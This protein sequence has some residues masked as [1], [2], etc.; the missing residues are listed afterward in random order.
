MTTRI[1][2]FDFSINLLRALLWQDN[3][4]PKM[5]ALL[6]Q[7]QDWYEANVSTFWTN[8]IADV[9]DIRTANEFGLSVWAIIL[10]LP[11]EFIAPDN[12]GPQF[13]FGPASNGRVNFNHGNFGSSQAGVGLTLEQKRILLRLRYYRLINRCSVTEINAM[14]A[15]LLS[16]Y[17][18]MYV[19][20][21]LDM[22]MTY[23]YLFPPNSKLQFVL[24]NF[25]ILPRPA[26]V[27]LKFISGTRQGIFGFG[28]FNDN[29]ENGTFGAGTVSEQILDTGGEPLLDTNGQFIFAKD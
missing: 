7:K 16:P 17:G 4:A 19:L 6:Q 1:Q 8:W 2:Q 3:N 29:F 12:Q 11:L 15:E 23:V 9:F 13:G 18:K 25:D 24:E 5:T 28:T 26:G 22:T 14:L 27:E 21:G 10:G 20:D